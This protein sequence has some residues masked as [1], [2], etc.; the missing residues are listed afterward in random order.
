MSAGDPGDAGDQRRRLKDAGADHDADRDHRWH[1]RRSAP[2]RVHR[3]RSARAACDGRVA[4]RRSDSSR[5]R[6]RAYSARADVA[7]RSLSPRV[8]RASIRSPFDLARHASSARRS[9]HERQVELRAAQL[10]VRERLPGSSPA[11]PLICWNVCSRC[12]TNRSLPPFCWNCQVP[13]D[14]RGH[15]PQVRIAVVGHRAVV[16]LPIVHQERMRHHAR[17]GLHLRESSAAGAGSARAADTAS[18]PSPC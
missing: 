14:V 8:T 11:V 10:R 7:R 3:E 17:A 18:R 16:R 13:V 9:R 15:D 2:A 4:A 6:S 5:R 1:R 12:I